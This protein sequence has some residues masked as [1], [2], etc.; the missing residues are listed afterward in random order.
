MLGFD[1]SIAGFTTWSAEGHGYSFANTSVSERVRGSVRRQVI[2]S[3]L[4]RKTANA[5]LRAIE[6]SAPNLGLAYWIEPV[7]SFGRMEWRE[8]RPGSATQD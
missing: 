1:P 5:L 7:E 6:Q 3:I 4:D 8:E 2:T